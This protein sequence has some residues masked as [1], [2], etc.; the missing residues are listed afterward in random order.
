M[1]IAWLIMTTLG[2]MKVVD[3]KNDNSRPSDLC[4]K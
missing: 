1:T 3:D 4:C 2:I